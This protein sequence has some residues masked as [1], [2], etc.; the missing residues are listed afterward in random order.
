MKL[1]CTIAYAIHATCNLARAMPGVPIPC[2]QLARQGKLPERFLLQILRKLVKVGL[3]EST[4]GVAGGYFLSRSPQQISLRDIITAFD[5]PLETLLPV[6]G[7]V[8]GPIHS[9][10]V[11]VLEAA[12]G[13]A[14]AELQKVSIAELV[15]VDGERV[16]SAI[17]R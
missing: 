2:S 1:S 14:S 5:N 17:T 12:S 10:I 3:L 4:C 16:W 9:R 6:E 11:Q 15:R 8:S 13:A 7:G